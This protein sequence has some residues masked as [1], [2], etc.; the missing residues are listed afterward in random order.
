MSFLKNVKLGQTIRNGKFSEFTLDI[1]RKKSKRGSIFNS[2]RMSLVLKLTKIKKK[3]SSN[4]CILRKNQTHV[5]DL[6][7]PCQF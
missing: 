2:K 5:L 4:I 7:V 1:P 6:D 3:L